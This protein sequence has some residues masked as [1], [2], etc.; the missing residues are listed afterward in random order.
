[1]GLFFFSFFFPG[2]GFHLLLFV[3][4]FMIIKG[5]IWSLF[6]S[7]FHRAKFGAKCPTLGVPGCVHVLN[8]EGL[9]WIWYFMPSL[10]LQISLLTGRL[11]F[12]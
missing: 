9:F 2:E 7:F 12:L 10:Q 4:L 5:L 3:I 8:P 11:S 1:M 6:Y